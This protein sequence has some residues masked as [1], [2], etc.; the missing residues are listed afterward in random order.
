MIF[1]SAVRVWLTSRTL[2]CT[3]DFRGRWTP[4]YKKSWMQPFSMACNDTER[5]NLGEC[6]PTDGRT[7]ITVVRAQKDRLI[8]SSSIS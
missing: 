3:G 4:W 5:E 6:I 7:G 8:C 2:V 1:K